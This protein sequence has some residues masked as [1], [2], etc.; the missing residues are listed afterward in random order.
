[1]ITVNNEE[2]KVETIENK[3]EILPS[4]RTEKDGDNQY[5]TTTST[6]Y[7]FGAFSIDKKDIKYYED[8]MSNEITGEEKNYP[9]T[10]L[11]YALDNEGWTLSSV[12]SDQWMLVQLNHDTSDDYMNIECDLMENGLL[13]AYLI[14]KQINEK[15]EGYKS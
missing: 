13:A 11:I 4:L 15:D 8:I 7:S 6:I 1:M 5:R 14:A 2:V 9:S 12:I 3:V 10:A